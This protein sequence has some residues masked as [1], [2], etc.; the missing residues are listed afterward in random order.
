MLCY[1]PRSVNSYP[2]PDELKSGKEVKLKA[3]RTCLERREHRVRPF[4]IIYLFI[5]FLQSTQDT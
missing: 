5:A 1:I 3:H 4:I 2:S